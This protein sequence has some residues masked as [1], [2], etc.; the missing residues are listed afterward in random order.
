MSALALIVS[1]AG[2]IAGLL[3]V[4]VCRK[5]FS[6]VAVVLELWMAAGL[7]NLAVD[8]SWSALGAAAS[9]VAIRTMGNIGLRS[10]RQ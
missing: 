9:I 1:A 5:F 7:L 8:A 4:L 3:I 6:A 10:A 2:V